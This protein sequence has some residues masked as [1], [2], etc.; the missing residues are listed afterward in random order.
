[1]V[2]RPN[3]DK[4]RLTAM[5]ERFAEE[6]IV[7]LHQV[8]AYIRAGYAEQHAHKNAT[9]LLKRP[10]VMNR[11]K[12]LILERREQ[13][14]INSAYFVDKLLQ[15]IEHCMQITE[16]G[17]MRNTMGAL[18]GLE[19]VAKYIGMDIREEA[20]DEAKTITVKFE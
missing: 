13:L 17:N 1:M 8:N 3:N 19:M 2:A 20:Q 11:V 4:N 15:T 5:E 6:Y 12:E 14:Q 7:D 18:K 9:S 16:R 10:Q